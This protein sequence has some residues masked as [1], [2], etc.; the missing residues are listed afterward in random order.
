ML[1]VLPDMI[2]SAK[3]IF[4]DLSTLN[5]LVER[6]PVFQTALQ[7]GKVRSLSRYTHIVRWIKSTSELQL[8]R[9]AASITCQVCLMPA[10]VNI[11][12]IK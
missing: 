6:L 11:T 5:P 12:G 1:Q 7:Q 9:Q 2:G 3:S 4:C 8:M 10:S